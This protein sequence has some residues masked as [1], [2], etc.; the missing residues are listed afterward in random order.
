VEAAVAAGQDANAFGQRLSFFFNCHNNLLE[1]IAKFRAARR[2]WAHIM[3]DRFHATNPRAQ[4]LRFH[5]QTAGSSLTSAQPENNIVRVALQAIAAVLG[6]TQSLHTNGQDEALGLPTESS[7][8][9]ALRTQQIIAHE[10]GV[11]NT[12]DPMGGAW[13]IE[14]LTDQIEGA[15]R[16]ILDRID[17]LGGTL[18]AIEQG[19]IQL[20]IQ[21]SAYRTQQNIERGE[22]VVVGV[23]R[24]NEDEATPMEVLH[25]DP[26]L[27]VR[28]IARVRAVRASRDEASWRRSLDAVERAAAG[29][30]NLVPPILAAVEANATVGEISDAMRR[31]FGEY[32]DPSLA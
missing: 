19:A 12:V 10:S 27:E 32:R 28:Q 1:E 26:A 8:R 7:A 9:I 30:Q 15:A 25:I 5:T 23:N 2:L 3:R 14:A 22:Q 17:R 31:V 11:A 29:G 20:D 4:Q 6:G 21:E 24:F 13:A 16:E 18:T